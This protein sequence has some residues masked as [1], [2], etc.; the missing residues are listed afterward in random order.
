MQTG[1]PREGGVG[2][3]GGGGTHFNIVMLRK[4]EAHE[5]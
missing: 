4:R 1:T 3:P 5:I 2:T